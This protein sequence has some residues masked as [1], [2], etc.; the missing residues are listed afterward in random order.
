MFPEFQKAK[1]A[2]EGDNSTLGEPSKQ[3][4]RMM[5]V[6]LGPNVPEG[7][8]VHDIYTKYIEQFNKLLLMYIKDS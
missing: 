4:I 7:D 3:V 8:Y 5:Y 6:I 1:E 2:Y